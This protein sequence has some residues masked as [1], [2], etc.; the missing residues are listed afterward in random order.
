MDQHE[1]N[2]VIEQAK[3]AR[4]EAIASVVR[5]HP[6]AASSLVATLVLSLQADSFLSGPIAAGLLHLKSLAAAF[7]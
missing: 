5:K 3:Q 4:A 6:I 1:I 2:A 7:V